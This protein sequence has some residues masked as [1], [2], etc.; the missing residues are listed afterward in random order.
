ME[1]TALR[2]MINTGWPDTRSDCP[3]HLLPYWTFREELGV[4]NG[5]VIKGNRIVVPKSLRNMALEKIHLA[6]QGIEKCRL[7]ARASVY[8]VGMN[9]DI[10]QMVRK[11]ATCQ[12]HQNSLPKEPLHSYDVPTGPW[13]TLSADLFHWEQSTYLLVAD[14]YSKFPLVRRLNSLSS[15]SVIDHMKVMFDEHGICQRLISDNGPQF[16][17]SEFK[18]FANVYGFEHITSS[19][20]FP[21]SNGFMERQVE[22]VKELFTKARETGTDPHLAMLCLR[23]TPVDHN[24]PSPCELLNSRV[25]RSNLPGRIPPNSSHHSNALQ[26]RQD[27]SNKR[28]ERNRPLSELKP[29]QPVRVQHPVNKTWEP[30]R[31]ITRTNEPRSYKVETPRGVYR[32]NRRHIRPTA[33]TFREKDFR[34]HDNDIAVATPEPDSIVTNTPVKDG[35]TVADVPALRRSQRTIKKPQRLDL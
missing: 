15:R 19:P 14:Q 8:W 18:E 23:T 21:S 13:H 33:E 32:H 9:N 17:S 4:A 12:K 16:D 27:V 25:Y 7:R 11:C 5:V 28:F 24:L 30:G 1:L 22:T 10:E 29:H 2:D 3:A 31:I 35:T 26:R 20:H 34:R 6:H